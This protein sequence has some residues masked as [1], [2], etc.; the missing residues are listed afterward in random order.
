M[1]YLLYSHIHIKIVLFLFIMFPGFLAYKASNSDVRHNIDSIITKYVEN[2]TKIIF[3]RQKRSS[4]SDLQP[5]K[6]KV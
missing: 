6:G 3:Q 1:V 4:P 5:S 2:T